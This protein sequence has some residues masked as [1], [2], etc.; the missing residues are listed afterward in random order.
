MLYSLRILYSGVA[1]AR[2]RHQALSLVARSCFDFA[3]RR[4]LAFYAREAGV[5]VSLA[6]SAWIRAARHRAAQCFH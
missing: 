5:P 3:G 4:A 2:S 6:R 1:D